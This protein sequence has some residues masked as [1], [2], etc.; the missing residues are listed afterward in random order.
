MSMMISREI[1]V[2]YLFICNLLSFYAYSL[3]L[4]IFLRC[5]LISLRI[6]RIQKYQSH[7]PS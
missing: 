1:L 3:F 7:Y 2:V 4:L 6:I 5:R